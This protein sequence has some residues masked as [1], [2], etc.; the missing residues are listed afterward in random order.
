MSAPGAR[1][2]TFDFDHLIE[3]ANA[4]GAENDEQRAEKAGIS[5]RTYY[6]LQAACRS[7]EE[8]ALTLSRLGEIAANLGTTS[9][10]LMG[11][12]S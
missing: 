2:S 1:N 6:R 5:I 10:R 9:L 12:T 8:V 7:G 3:R 11:V 4:L